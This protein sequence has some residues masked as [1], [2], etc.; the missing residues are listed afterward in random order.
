MQ[1]PVRNG[2]REPTADVTWQ[3]SADAEHSR[4][5]PAFLLKLA[6]VMED[7]QSRPF[8]RWSHGGAFL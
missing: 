6:A 3:D 8:V 4:V 1:Q 5:I 2:Q 7:A